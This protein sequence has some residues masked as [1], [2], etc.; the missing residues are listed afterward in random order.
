MKYRPNIHQVE[1]LWEVECIGG[2]LTNS[3]LTLCFLL[4]Q[5][6]G[7]WEPCNE[8]V[9]LSLAEHLVDLNWEPS[10]SNSSASNYQ[11]REFMCKVSHFIHKMNNLVKK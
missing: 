10:N 7:H 2:S 6:K 5:P 4:V 9:S 8:V 3:M 1:N 11:A